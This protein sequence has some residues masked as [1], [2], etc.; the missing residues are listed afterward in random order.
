MKTKFLIFIQIL[1]IILSIL[2]IAAHFYRAGN[3][4]L[5]YILIS[6]PLILLFRNRI[7]VRI[8]QILLFFAT[9]EW[10]RVIY[11]VAH[12][13]KMYNLPWIRFSIIMS[14]VALFTFATIFIFY[15]K[16]LKKIYFR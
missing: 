3:Q 5:T 9:I 16:T 2:L 13:R 1:A 14:S 6:T 12:I 10:W 4:I 11:N 15:S 7:S 8:I